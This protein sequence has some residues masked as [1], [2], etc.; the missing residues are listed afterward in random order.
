MSKVTK[1][2][3]KLNEPV[4]MGSDT[5]TE[6]SWNDPVKWKVMKHMF[7][8]N[9]G[10]ERLTNFYAAL[11]NQPPSVVDELGAEDIAAV[12]KEV[13]HFFAS[14]QDLPQGLSEAT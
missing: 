14:M 5:I 6:V 11:L 1:K 8:G 7:R 12:W 2:T 10:D 9:G 4:V 3:R 13:Q